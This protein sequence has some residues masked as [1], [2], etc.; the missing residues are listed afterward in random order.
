MRDF[1]KELDEIS[2]GFRGYDKEETMLY[3]KDLLQYCEEEKKKDMD[4]LIEQSD[5][6][7]KELNEAK[8]REA[9]QKRQYDALLEKFEKLSDAVSENAKHNAER[10]SQLDDF[11]RKEEEIKTLLQQ[12]REEAD[13]EKKKLMAET[14]EKCLKVLAQAEEEK[15]KIIDNANEQVLEIRTKSFEE[16]KRVKAET[17]YL[18]GELDQLAERLRP[19][20]Y[21]GGTGEQENAPGSRNHAIT[22]TQAEGLMSDDVK[23]L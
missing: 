3:I 15:K 6:L 23:G 17:T 11:H 22:G 8:D 9:E 2:T 7:R 12:T 4:K 18:R 13:A 21:P 19:L 16:N 5:T 20:L 14:K 10:D 1:I